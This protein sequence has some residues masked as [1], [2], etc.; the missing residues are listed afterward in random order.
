MDD[1][2]SS[3]PAYQR[4]S[5]AIA[6]QIAAGDLK[7]G[8]QLPSERQLGE[9][10]GASRMTVRQAMRTL[11][12]RGL[13]ETRSGLGS[14][15]GRQVHE[16]PIS[17]LSGFTEAMRRVGRASSS[18]VLSAGS[19][20]ASLEAARALEIPQ[21]SPVHRLVRVRLVDSVAI[22]IE[23][24]DIPVDVLPNLFSLADFG[25][26]SLYSVL[27][28]NGITPTEGEQSLTA[29]LPDHA[30]ALTLQITPQ[31]PVLNLIRR[32]LDQHRNPIEYVRSVYRGDSV[33][34]TVQLR[35]VN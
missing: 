34:M 11:S 24:T 20:T 8:E 17:T 23:T 35:I 2:A 7:P 13:I 26:A 31:T 28:L 5:Q 33:A 6:D 22:A 30:T 19:A 4:I 18:I 27:R 32:T 14:F 16:Q 21:G 15:V 29:A 1:S 3:V 9:A 10:F 12:E 25:S